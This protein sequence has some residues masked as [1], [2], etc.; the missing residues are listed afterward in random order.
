MHL[1]QQQQLVVVYDTQVNEDD[2]PKL[3]ELELAKLDAHR[4]VLIARML[5]PH[6][7]QMKAGGGLGE[8]ASLTACPECR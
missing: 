3:Q 8:G 5:N 7:V 2:M 1:Q 4:R 6:A